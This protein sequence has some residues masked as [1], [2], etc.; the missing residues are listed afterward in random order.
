MQQALPLHRL[1]GAALQTVFKVRI[2]AAAIYNVRIGRGARDPKVFPHTQNH[3]LAGVTVC[4]V[5]FSAIGLLWS[6]IAVIVIGAQSGA[7]RGTTYAW[8][9]LTLILNIVKL[10]LASRILTLHAPLASWL[11]EQAPQQVAQPNVI[12]IQMPGQQLQQQ[13]V[14]FVPPP[15]FYAP[16]QQI[17]HHPHH[18]QYV[19]T[20][21]YY[22]HPGIQQGGHLSSMEAPE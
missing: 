13:P 21:Q 15:V 11:L 7:N 4:L 5:V 6:A 8:L 14:Q 20:N 10:S 16:Q 19:S 3:H 2:A 18:I 9:V 1:Y 17:H 12:V 22:G